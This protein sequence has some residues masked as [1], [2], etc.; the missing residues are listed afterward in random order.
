MTKKPRIPHKFHPWIDARKK[1]RLS[2]AHIQM[3]RELGLSPKRFASY[4]DR[5]N[6]P[7]K[8]PLVEF[9]ETQYQKQFGKSRPDTVVSVE[10]LAAAHVAKRAARKE[11]SAKAAEELP[12]QD[13]PTETAPPEDG[14]LAA[15][16]SEPESE[17][18]GSETNVPQSNIDNIG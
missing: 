3:A 4:A 18:S 17:S 8:L 10:E 2:D 12:K 16:A 9:I 11:A 15:P 14:P 6:K 1:F 5:K 13:A 7:W